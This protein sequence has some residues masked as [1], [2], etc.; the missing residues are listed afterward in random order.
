MRSAPSRSRQR[1]AAAR[2]GALAAALIG[3]LVLAGCDASENAD[4]E[5]GRSLFQ[6]NCG[7]CHTLAEAGTSATVGPNLD[8]AFSEARENGMDNDTIEGVVQGQIEHPREIDKGAENYTQVYMPAEIVT[9]QDAE[10]VATYVAGVAG[11]PGA[12]PPQL[13]PDQLFTEQCG[14]CHALDAAG[15]SSATGPDL[16]QALKGKNAAF[17]EKQI[18]DPNSQIAQGFQPNVMP[19]DFQTRLSQKDLQ[20]LVDYILQSVGGN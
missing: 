10:D 19:Q 2:L 4:V 20:G 14:I 9:G 12:K 11:V 6:A 7:T 15:T 1:I 8:E 16:D 3:A 17:I 18:V 13:P 5:R